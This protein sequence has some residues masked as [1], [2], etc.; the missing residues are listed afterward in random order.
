MDIKKPYHHNI[1]IENNTFHPFDYPV[2]Y[3]RSTQGLYFNNN[4]L[5]RSNRFKPF[6][7]RKYMITLEAC[8]KVEING[9]HLSP[10]ILGKNINLIATPGKEI[11]LDKKQGIKMDIQ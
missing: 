5:T 9:N 2:L 10:D 1:R 11:K 6:H 4:T 3:A 7:P 8:S